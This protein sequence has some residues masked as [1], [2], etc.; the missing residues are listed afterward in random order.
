MPDR[1][2]TFDKIVNW[3][4]GVFVVAGALSFMSALG[5]SVAESC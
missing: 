2:D 4:I 5:L 3:V 1:D